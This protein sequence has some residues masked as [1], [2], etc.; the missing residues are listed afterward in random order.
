MLPVESSATG[1]LSLRRK[2]PRVS[3]RESSRR[4][5]KAS[6]PRAKLA[7]SAS[8]IGYA[9]SP[10]TTIGYSGNCAVIVP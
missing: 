4:N 8:S 3:G 1:S 2:R 6:A 10:V 9:R 5:R 7:L